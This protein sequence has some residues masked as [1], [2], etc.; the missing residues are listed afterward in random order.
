MEMGSAAP[1]F[2]AHRVGSVPPSLSSSQVEPR[3]GARGPPGPCRPGGGPGRGSESGVPGP[4]T[5][6]SPGIL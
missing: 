5:S 3:P 6:A 1:R 2:S 4:A